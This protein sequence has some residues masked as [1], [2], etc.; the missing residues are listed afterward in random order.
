MA[1]QQKKIRLFLGVKVAMSTV[2]ALAEAAEF[3][4]REAYDAGYQIR[5]VVPATYHV[6]LKFLGWTQPEIVA[7]VRDRLDSRLAQIPSFEF[8]TAGVGAFPNPQ[9]ARVVWAG[10]DDPQ[11]RLAELAGVIEEELETLGFPKEKRPFHPHV[12]LGRVKRVDDVSAVLQRA[13]EQNFRKTRVETVTLFESIMKSVGSEYVS[14]AEIELFSGR[15]ESKRQTEQLQRRA[16]RELR[17]DDSDSHTG[18]P[19]TGNQAD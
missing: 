10:I 17:D 14:R 13:T 19:D 8:T 18:N 16:K 6:T 11:G 12:T 15:S 1:S 2:G 5:W 4:R 3:M 9:N 7:L